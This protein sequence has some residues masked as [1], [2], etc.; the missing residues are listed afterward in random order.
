MPQ[1]CQWASSIAG[2]RF[3]VLAL[4][5]GFAGACA[6]DTT[7]PS[8]EVAVGADVPETS[9]GVEIL[10]LDDPAFLT[11][12]TS[13]TPFGFWRLEYS[14][15]SSMYTSLHGGASAETIKSKLETARRK[16][17][18]V[19]VQFAGRRKWYQTSSGA[20]SLDKFK[21]RLA[22]FKNLNLDTYINDGTLAG[23]QMIDEPSDASNWGGKAMSYSQVEAAAKASKALWPRLP[24]L[25]RTTP[26]WLKGASFKW[27]YLDGA[28]AQYSARKGD[29]YKY[30]DAEVAI[31]KAEGLNLVWG[32]NVIDGGDGSSGRRGTSSGKYNM[33]GSELKKYGKALLY[34]PR[35]CG[36]LMWMYDDTYLSRSS[37]MDAH[38]V[39][40]QHGQEP[41]LPAL[42]RYVTPRGRLDL[43]YR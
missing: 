9:G 23:H 36:F 29:V 18:R 39:L 17:A 10:N 42:Q 37:V 38:E 30:R 20:F 2:L 25:V 43:E 27:Y 15:L 40:G 1:M 41:A 32:L 8:T 35:T 6:S 28:W 13:N 12:T 14:Q 19:F 11:A 16:G 33:S 3:V 34:A 21:S 7:D 22:A 4:V 26:S 24:A 5:A 31:A